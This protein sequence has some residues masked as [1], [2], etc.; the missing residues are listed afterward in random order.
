MS[1]KLITLNALMTQIASEEITISDCQIEK[2]DQGDILNISCWAMKQPDV[3]WFTISMPYLP[4][5][6]EKYDLGDLG[7]KVQKGFKNLGDFLNKK[8]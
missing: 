4:E 1:D 6:V 3:L 2:T 5:V 7:V 8:K